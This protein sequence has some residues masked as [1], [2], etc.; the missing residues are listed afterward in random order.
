MGKFSLIQ[1]TEEKRKKEAL[2]IG[3]KERDKELQLLL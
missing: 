3:Q 1:E 2:T